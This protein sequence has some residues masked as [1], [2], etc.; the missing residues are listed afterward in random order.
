VLGEEDASV[1]VV[2]LQHGDLLLPFWVVAVSEVFTSVHGGTLMSA[3]LE[4]EAH[5]KP[6]NTR[7]AV[8]NRGRM[9]L[10]VLMLFRKGCSLRKT[11]LRNAC[12]AT[13]H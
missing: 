8:G 12:G 5:A 9:K 2:G 10:Q 13:W 11:M 4:A 7:D 3:E 6:L 1:D